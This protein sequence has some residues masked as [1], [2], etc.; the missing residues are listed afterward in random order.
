MVS[1][2]TVDGLHVYV[3]DGLEQISESLFADHLRLLPAWRRRQASSF[4]RH[5]DQLLCVEAYRL[6]QRALREHY[7]IEGQPAFR[8]GPCGKPRLAGYPQIHFSLSHCERGVLCVVGDMPMGCDIEAVGTVPDQDV[9][10]ACYSAGERSAVC[11][12][13]VPAVAFTRLWTC[14]EAL[15]KLSGL[16]LSADRLPNVLS[17]EVTARYLFTT[18]ER[19]AQG[20]VWTVCRSREGLPIP[21]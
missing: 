15:L 4:R 5:I 10:A 12:S 18:C 13:P 6:L 7:G 9:M 14:K 21:F 19:M 20:Y 16:G 17:S 8:Y 1:S 3:L 11:E 2:L